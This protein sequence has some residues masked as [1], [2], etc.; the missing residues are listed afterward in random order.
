MTIDSGVG[1]LKN[2]GG[3]ANCLVLALYICT[4]K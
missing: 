4:K 1:I 2:I 3:G